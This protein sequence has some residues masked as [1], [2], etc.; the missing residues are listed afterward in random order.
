[1]PDRRA[2]IEALL[3]APV[4][5]RRGRA[6]VAA[7]RAMMEER[8]VR[9]M[10]VQSAWDAP[11]AALPALV[12]ERSLEEFVEDD[13]PEELVRAFIARAWEL[14]S[15]KGFDSGVKLALSLIGVDAE[16]EQWHQLDPEGPY[17]THSVE[18]IGAREAYPGDGVLGPRQW[19]ALFRLIEKTKRQSQSTAIRTRERDVLHFRTGFAQHEADLTTVRPSPDLRTTPVQLRTGF[20]DRVVDL[21]RIGLYAPDFGEQQIRVRSGFAHRVLD[22]GVVF[23]GQDAPPSNALYDD[24]GKPLMDGGQYVVAEE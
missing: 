11:A 4:N 3:P 24:D 5:D 23:A 7:M 14:H 21:S 12:A 8:P 19:A 18:V 6:F 15:E 17:F 1:M 16:I 22:L 9:S 10:I 2:E 13:M 20:A